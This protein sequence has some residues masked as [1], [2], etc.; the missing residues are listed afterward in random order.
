MTLEHPE[1]LALKPIKMSSKQ[2]TYREYFKL[3]T[4]LKDC[5][6][7]AEQVDMYHQP[8]LVDCDN[9]VLC[10]LCL[11]LLNKESTETDYRS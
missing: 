5:F 2:T 10:S 9:T 11:S 6:I 3:H 4:L 7:A 1:K 8:G